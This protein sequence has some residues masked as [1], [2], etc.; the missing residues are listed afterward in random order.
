MAERRQS[1]VW[2]SA[3]TVT[4]VSDVTLA[5]ALL[6]WQE[7]SAGRINVYADQLDHNAQ[8]S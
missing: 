4:I 2:H 8:K 1:S 5:T 3:G 6:A 7:H